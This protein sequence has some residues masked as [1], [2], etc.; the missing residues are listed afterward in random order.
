MVNREIDYPALVKDI[1]RQ[2][3][4]SQEDL[5][6][7]LGV[8]FATVNRWENGQTRPSKLAKVQLEGFCARMARRGSLK[9]PQG[10]HG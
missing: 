2:L 5:A 9:P 4:L 8:S 3:G 10:F 6:R 1:R 7:E